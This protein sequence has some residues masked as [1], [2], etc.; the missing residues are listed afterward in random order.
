[1]STREIVERLECFLQIL[2]DQYSPHITGT[3]GRGMMRGLRFADPRFAARVARRALEEGLV[4]ARSGPRGEFVM[5]LVP[6]AITEEQ[7]KEVLYVFACCIAM[8]YGACEFEETPEQR[9]A[10]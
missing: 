7:M 4:I 2:V 6:P 10:V 3:W 9:R 5:C 1:M 8:E